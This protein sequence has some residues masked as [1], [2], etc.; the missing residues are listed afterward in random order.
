MINIIKVLIIF[1]PFVA[2]SQGSITNVR[3]EQVNQ[4]LEI[5]YD[6]D[7]VQ[8]GDFLKVIIKTRSSQKSFVPN[9]LTGSFGN[10]IRSGTNKLIVWNMVEDNIRIDEEISAELTIVRPSTGAGTTVANTKPTS[11]SQ[12]VTTAKTST[13]PA[14]EKRFGKALASIPVPGLG[15]YLVTGKSKP[16]LRVVTGVAAFG[17]LTTS[18]I[19]NKKSNN[20]YSIY[21]SLLRRQEAQPYY[22]K[23]NGL[24]K[25]S[26]ITGVLA[27]AVWATEL[28]SAITNS[29]KPLPAKRVGLSFK[30]GYAFNTPVVGISYQF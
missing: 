4:N 20:Q 27:F 23:A 14:S 25:V 5:R 26:Y 22:D 9:S 11:P 7:G 1:L 16:I 28:T 21:E 18:F 24:H 8:P 2:F 15:N 12:P 29:M 13:I 6:C 30:S 3:I 19:T 17:L 10:D